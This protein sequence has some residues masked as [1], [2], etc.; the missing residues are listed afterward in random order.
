[1][2]PE[3]TRRDGGAVPGEYGGAGEEGGPVGSGPVGG[4][5]VGGGPAGGEPVAVPES[6]KSPG[7]V[8][9]WRRALLAVLV[10]AAVVVPVS[11]AAHPQIPAPAPAR[12]APLTRTGLD[13]A[14]AANRAD[15]AQASRMAAAHG[16]VHRAAVDGSLAAPSRQLLAFD[17]RGSGRATEV[18]GDLAHADRIA[19]VVPGSDTSLDTYSRLRRDT[20]ALYRELT[21]RAPAGTRTA[22]VAWL[23]YQTPGTVSAT[24][25]TTGRAD[26]AAPHLRE[27]IRD[28]RAMVGQEPRITTV[29][30]SYGSVVCGRAA[31]GLDVND[32]A[33]IGS[34]GTGA[35]SV[36]Q[37]HTPAR[38]WAARGADDWVADVPHGRVGL[39][40]TALGLGT[41]P[42]DPAFGAR[43]FDAG[44]GGHSAY[45]RPGSP[46]LTNLARI[47]LDTTKEMR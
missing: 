10:T 19:V 34:P 30:H 24:V 15:A 16:D 44:Q 35:D 11:A 39:F 4:E 22:V 18:I 45:F 14:Y 33:L 25:L 37:L 38:V 32:I 17:G 1:M 23:G 7:P 40:G 36:A 42:T 27:L 5:P 43:V 9:R 20:L 26:Q 31:A 2:G 21:R 13:A 46:S 28:L 8:H 41:D 12:L 29:C 3:R 6:R 47:V